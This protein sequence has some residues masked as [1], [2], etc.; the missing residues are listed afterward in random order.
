MSGH[1]LEALV[2]FVYFLHK[3]IYKFNKTSIKIL[4]KVL[5]LIIYFKMYMKN[6]FEKSNIWKTYTSWFQGCNKATAVRTGNR[7]M[8]QMESSEIE[9]CISG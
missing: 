9:Q 2:V 5:K 8:Q 6:N 3:N 1:E 7:S 4:V